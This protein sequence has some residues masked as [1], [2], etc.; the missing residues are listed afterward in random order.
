M[1]YKYKWYEFKP[2]DGGLP[3]VPKEPIGYDLSDSRLVRYSLAALF[4][5]GGYRSWVGDSTYG[6]AIAG[7]AFV[8]AAVLAREISISTLGILKW[9]ALILVAAVSLWAA[10]RSPAFAI[11]LAL[12]VVAWIFRHGD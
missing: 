7:C 2:S 4:A 12:F 3:E 10:V 5:Y 8:L 6:L 9:P 11:F 1:A